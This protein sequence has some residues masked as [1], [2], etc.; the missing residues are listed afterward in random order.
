MADQSGIWYPL[1]MLVA[2]LGKLLY[3][4][5]L[6]YQ[7]IVNTS[8]EV[9]FVMMDDPDCCNSYRNR[10][11]DGCNS[12]YCKEKLMIKILQKINS[13]RHSID[14]AMYNFSNKQLVNSIMNARMRRVKIRIIM[15]KSVLMEKTESDLIKFKRAGSSFLFNLILLDS[16]PLSHS[17]YDLFIIFGFTKASISDL[18]EKKRN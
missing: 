7:D 13:A 11:V 5:Y 8:I 6:H 17:Y 14:I 2:V 12:K 4:Q 18:L 3:D 9:F 10:S 1:L 15:D 16:S